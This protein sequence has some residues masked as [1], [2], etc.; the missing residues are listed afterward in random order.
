MTGLSVRS[1]ESRR[2]RLRKKLDLNRDTSLLS[3]ISD[4]ELVEST[5]EP[6]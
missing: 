2:Y 3:F 4:I 6:S 1:V 5:Q